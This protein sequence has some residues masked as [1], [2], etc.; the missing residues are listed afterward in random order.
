MWRP[1]DAGYYAYSFQ[2]GG[3]VAGMPSPIT[4]SCWA[5]FRTG[6]T[7]GD[8]W[9]WGNGNGYWNFARQGGSNTVYSHVS[10]GGSH[11]FRNHSAIGADPTNWYHILGYLD[12]PATF[13]HGI[14]ING[15]GGVTG[16][17]LQIPSN[18]G[19]ALTSYDSNIDICHCAVWDVTFTA[20][21]IATLWT[22]DPL[23]VK[24][25]NLRGYWPYARGAGLRQCAPR[26]QG[27]NAQVWGTTPPQ[28]ILDDDGPPVSLN[29]ERLDGRPLV[30]VEGLV[31]AA[32]LDFI[33]SAV[34]V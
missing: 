2:G 34:V 19:W 5:R 18:P 9:I 27:G 14:F 11:S 15:S 25:R 16:T 21:E 33:P 26:G 30:P 29:W 20:A 7:G 13:E 32:A 24:P 1:F 4:W 28:A 12:R 6:V 3:N 22:K 8:E 17:T 10:D 31:A 23:T